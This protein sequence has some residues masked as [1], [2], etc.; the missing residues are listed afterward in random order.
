MS[1]K[2]AVLARPEPYYA[3]P[4]CGAQLDY[5]D[6]DDVPWGGYLYC[7]ECADEAY[8]G[9]TGKWLGGIY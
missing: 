6:G 2:D 7:P 3:C 1:R 5:Y 8:E 9:I 4:T